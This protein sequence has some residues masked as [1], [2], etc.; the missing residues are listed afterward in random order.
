MRLLALAALIIP[1]ALWAAEPLS[2]LPGDPGKAFSWST[3]KVAGAKREPITVAGKSFTDAWRF[4]VPVKGEKEWEV[5]SL[6][7]LPGGVAKGDVVEVSLWTRNAG[8]GTP[9]FRLVHQL[10]DTPWTN[11]I[12][13][14][15]KPEAEWK[16]YRYAAVAPIDFV[17]GSHRLALFLAT[18]A[19][20]VE[21]ADPQIRNHGAIDAK[22]LG[23]PVWEPPK[24]AK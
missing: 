1:A 10:K 16:Q 5:N 2:L 21:I 13:Q 4:T 22:S 14:T 11:S 24:P 7:V 23:I 20:T 18:D 17:A 19:M 6:C 3:G 12:Y 15:V 8:E 9:G